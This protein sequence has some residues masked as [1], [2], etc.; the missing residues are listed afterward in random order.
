MSAL[1][2][3]VV[4]LLT[5]G[6]VWRLLRP[7]VPKWIADIEHRQRAL[8][9]MGRWD[10]PTLGRTRDRRDGDDA[11]YDDAYF[12]DWPAFADD[13]TRDIDAYRPTSGSGSP[14]RMGDLGGRW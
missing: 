13:R 9:V 10:A 7:P 4:I 2:T 8:D 14:P 6:L 5:V 12:S 11:R 1:W 3:V